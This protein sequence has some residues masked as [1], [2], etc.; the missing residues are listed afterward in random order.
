[1][2]GQ[3]IFDPHYWQFP[4]DIIL[5]PTLETTFDIEQVSADDW[6]IRDRT[7]LFK[8]IMQLRELFIVNYLFNNCEH[9]FEVLIHVLPLA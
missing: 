4:P 2:I 5:P 3:I 6:D 7:C 9:I 8:Y 1:M